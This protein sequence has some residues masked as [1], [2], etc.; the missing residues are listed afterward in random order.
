MNRLTKCNDNWGDLLQ[1]ANI[2]TSETGFSSILFKRKSVI[3]DNSEIIT[4]SVS[5]R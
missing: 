4:W 1:I 3:S 2:E 5:T